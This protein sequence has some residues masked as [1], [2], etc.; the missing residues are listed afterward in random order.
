MK[1]YFVKNSFILPS[2]QIHYNHRL[3]RLQV[4][5]KTSSLNKKNNEIIR[6]IPYVLWISFE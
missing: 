4:C 3:S 5:V 1:R 2:C 6:L